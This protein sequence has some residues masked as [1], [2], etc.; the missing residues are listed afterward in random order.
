MSLNKDTEILKGPDGAAPKFK[1]IRKKKLNSQTGKVNSAYFICCRAILYRL[2][3][4][5]QSPR[6]PSS[7]LSFFSWYVIS[8]FKEHDNTI[9]LMGSDLDT[10]CISLFFI[11][12]RISSCKTWERLR[13]GSSDVYNYIQWYSSV[14][15]CSHKWFIW[16]LRLFESFSRI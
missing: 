7:F 6:I 4:W 12:C 1:G 14:V 9:W 8:N 3:S 16:T 13:R 10:H 2:W 5:F 15:V 11:P